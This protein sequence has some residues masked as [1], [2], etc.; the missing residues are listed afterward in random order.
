MIA[1]CSL[2]TE[3]WW[4]L[5]MIV[6]APLL[7]PDWAMTWAGGSWL[8]GSESCPSRSSAR[9]VAISLSRAVSRSARRRELAKTIVDRCCSTRS[10]TCSSTWGQMLVDRPGSPDVS[11]YS[12]GMVMSSTG[13]TTRRS[14]CFVLGGDTISTGCEPP[15]KR[16][17]SS[18]GRTVALRPMRC[19]GLSRS[20]SR[21]SRLI[22]R[23]APRLVP[24]TAW[25]S[26]MM[27]VS[28]LRR[29]SRAWLVSIRKSDSGVVM[30]MSG[31]VVPS[32]RRSAGL[33]SPDRSPTVTSGTVV[34]SRSA[35][36]RMPVR[37]ARRL[38]STSTP[39]ALSGEM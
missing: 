36:W 7:C 6:P 19:A 32:L 11:S 12:S 39:S 34:S 8:L 14:H 3:P 15:R 2:E 17:T 27:T 18:R 30:R 28:T 13:T 31:G 20:A 16:A 23:C 22:A 24:A 5:A 25:T 33:V 38:R 10:T 1:R 29:V 4:A 26:S 37:G 9:V 35:V 21:R